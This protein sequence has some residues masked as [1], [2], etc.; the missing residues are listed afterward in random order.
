MPARLFPY[1]SLLCISF[2]LLGAACDPFPEEEIPDPVPFWDSLNNVGPVRF[3]ALAVGQRTRYQRFEHNDQG[4]NN[5]NFTYQPD[6]LMLIVKSGSGNTFVVNE[7]QRSDT[8]VFG[9]YVYAEYQ[10]ELRN[11][12]LFYH[13]TS[14]NPP[15]L[16]GLQSSNLKF[17]LPLT[18]VS[19]PSATL[20]GWKPDAAGPDTWATANLAT[21]TQLGDTYTNLNVVADGRDQVTDGLGYVYLYSATEGLVRF[22]YYNSHG[23]WPNPKSY[24]WDRID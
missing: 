9:W 10:F 8:A 15:R 6:T 17:G 21:H 12:S 20:T 13:W 5:F 22:A 7:L 14:G 3:D 16:F 23:A 24:C 11:D 18:P 1:L 19:A 4:W 2:L